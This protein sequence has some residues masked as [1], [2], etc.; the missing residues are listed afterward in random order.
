[1]EHTEEEYRNY[2]SEI[3]VFISQVYEAEPEQPE[4]MAELEALQSIYGENSIRTW[5]GNGNGNG[6]KEWAP[7]EAIR[8]EVVTSLSP[9]Y[10]DTSLRLLVTLPQTYPHSTPPQLQ[11]LSKYIGPYPVTSQLF[12]GVLRT[13]LSQAHGVE[14]RLGE[15]AVF[16]GVES[17]KERVGRWFE[18]EK[19]RGEAL[20]VQR[21]MERE[22]QTGSETP[23]AR[24]EPPAPRVPMEVQ[25]TAELPDGIE[26]I[27]AEPIIDRKSVFVGRACKITHPSQ[28]PP[29]IAY[30]MSDRRIARAAHPV[31]HAWRCQVGNVLHQDNDDDG[32]SAA[33]G[34]IAHL[35]QILVYVL[36]IVTRYFGGILLG[37]DRFKHINQ[38]AR[39]ALELGGF[40]DTDDH[41]TAKS[42][43]GK[44]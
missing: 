32:E 21:E 36:V 15:V 25:V 40:L 8:Y 33:G 27:V 18:E 26:L 3:A 5:K 39:D 29:V 19:G 42:R 6:A 35:L 14:F 12:G 34:R 4:V 37:A 31:I 41:A 20:A 24:E 11:L 38:A 16:D 17:T 2:A 13:Y 28:V 30:L 7:G 43:K 9:P 23:K 22:R 1:M 10:E 44:K